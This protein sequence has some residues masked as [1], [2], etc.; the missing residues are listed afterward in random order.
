MGAAAQQLLNSRNAANRG[1][2]QAQRR[3]VRAAQPDSG[4]AVEVREQQQRG[5]AG[6][7]AGVPCQ[8]GG[9]SEATSV[10]GVPNL[11]V[12]CTKVAALDAVQHG[13]SAAPCSGTRVVQCLQS[14]HARWAGVFRWC[15]C[16]WNPDSDEKPKYVAYQVDINNCGPMML[17]A[18]FKIKDE[19]DQTLAFRRS[20]RCAGV[21]QGGEQDAAQAPL[22]PLHCHMSHMT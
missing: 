21:G 16:R 2:S 18:L 17:D 14:T 11:Q 8:A 22:R 19:N 7:Q 13:A 6:Q 3:S 20:C 9:G 1:R 15:Y 4:A 5:A 12:R 10:Q